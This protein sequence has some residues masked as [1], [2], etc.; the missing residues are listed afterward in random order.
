MLKDIHLQLFRSSAWLVNNQTFPDANENV[1]S[2]LFPQSS[3]KWP[4]PSH[5][6]LRASKRRMRSRMKM[7]P[8]FSSF[9][10]GDK[11]LVGLGRIAQ[12]QG[13]DWYPGLLG[14]WEQAGGIPYGCYSGISYIHD[15]EISTWTLIHRSE[16]ASDD[17]AAYFNSCA[18]IEPL[19]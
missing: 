17:A 15:R 12:G 7:R 10:S 5:T 3:P 2:F 19:N 9:N 18:I 1:L 4:H 14:E 8:M 6:P 16:D 13:K 11:V